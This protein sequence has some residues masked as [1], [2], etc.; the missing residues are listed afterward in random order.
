M[1]QPVRRSRCQCTVEVVTDQFHT[2]NSF[3]GSQTLALEALA[4]NLNGR[5]CLIGEGDLAVIECCFFHR[6]IRQQNLGNC[7][8]DHGNRAGSVRNGNGV[9]ATALV[10]L[11]A[12]TCT[13]QT[14]QE[15]AVGFIEDRELVVTLG[16]GTEDRAGTNNGNLNAD[17]LATQMPSLLNLTSMSFTLSPS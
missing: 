11:A 17:G 9:L 2:V 12:V 16:F 3:C 5:C 1:P 6:N 14:L 8:G 15:L 10:Q 4:A 13:A 7:F